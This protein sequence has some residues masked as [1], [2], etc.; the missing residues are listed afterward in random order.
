[1]AY[2]CSTMSG[3]SA[4][5]TQMA[6]GWNHWVTQKFRAWAEMAEGPAQL[7]ESIY[8]FSMWLVFLTAWHLG[9]KMSI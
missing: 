3:A 4:G 1:M 5:K 6:G 8:D 9:S 7:G 2:L